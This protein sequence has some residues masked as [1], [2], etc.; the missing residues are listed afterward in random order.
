M[1]KI[2]CIGFSAG[3]LEPFRTIVSSL[4]STMPA[5][6]LAASHRSEQ[7]PDYLAEILNRDGGMRAKIV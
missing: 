4:E 6:I 7:A 3:G 2:I 5:A 1:K